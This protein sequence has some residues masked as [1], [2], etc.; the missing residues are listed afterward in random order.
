M[1]TRVWESSNLSKHG[2]LPVYNRTVVTA[3]GAALEVKGKTTVSLKVKGKTTVS[4]KI[5]EESFDADVIVADLENELLIGLDFMR[6]HGCTVDV[7]NNVLIIQGKK[8]DL[9]CRGLIGCHR[10]VAKEDE[11]IPARSERII[12]GRVV[13]MTK[14]T[15][16]LYKVEP[17][18]ALRKDD[19][20]LVARALVQGSEYVSLQLMNVTDEPQIIRKSTNIATL[21]PACEVKRHCI[22]PAK[23]ENVPEHLKDLYERAVVGMTKVQKA[24]IAKLLKKYSNSFSKS[25]DDLGRT[26]IVRHKINTENSH[27]IKQPLQRTPVHLHSEM[28]KQI[29]DKLQRDV[30]QPSS[31]PWTSGIVIVS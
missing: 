25:D 11:I 24:E 10:V 19:R 9:N 13:N 15:N 18:N 1:S 7:E 16:N 6:R 3:F 8:C 4:L 29:D 20:G 5:G 12:T 30:I 31:S 28:D 22:R 27:P 2:M 26:G 23:Q 21:N 17:D 14:A